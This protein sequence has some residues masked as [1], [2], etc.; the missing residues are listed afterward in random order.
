MHGTG[1]CTQLGGRLKP[2]K[3]MP[4][5]C[6]CFPPPLC[7]SVQLTNAQVARIKSIKGADFTDALIRRDVQKSLCKIAGACGGRG[8]LHPAY[9]GLPQPACGLQRAA[10]G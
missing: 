4:C 1:C 7:S 8:R 9:G 2:L 5:S 6:S 3:P 10:A